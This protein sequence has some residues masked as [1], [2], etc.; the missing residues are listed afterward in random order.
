MKIARIA[1]T[2]F[3]VPLEEPFVTALRPVP[4]LE[5]VLVEVETDEGLVG[6]GEAAPGPLVTGETQAGITDVIETMLA[7]GLVGEDPLRT[8]HLVAK[9]DDLVGKVP[10]AKAAVDVALHDLKARAAE[11]PLYR[12]LGGDAVDSVLEVPAILSLKSPDEMVE[13]VTAAVEQGYR[14][15]KIKLGDNPETDVRRVRAVANAVPDD[16]H[17]KA[18]ANQGWSDAKTALRV[19]QECGEHLD[20]IEQPLVASDIEGLVAVRDRSPVPMMPDE[21]VWNATD[22]LS[23][24]RRGAGDRYNIKLMKSGGLHEAGGLNAVAAANHCP[25]QLGSMVEGHVGTAAGAHFVL[26]HSNVIGNDLVGPFLTT[27]GITDLSLDE[28]RIELDGPGLGVTI[29]R[30]VLSDLAVDRTKVTA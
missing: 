2:Q 14:G 23:L 1:I 12:L 27:T 6:V 28:P 30:D 17:L 3:D 7:P 16:V 13:D 26:A 20:V 15:V 9:L 25:T 29:D 8:E 4:K 22:A 11:M 21:S 5:R 19:L 18:D 24:V 10:T